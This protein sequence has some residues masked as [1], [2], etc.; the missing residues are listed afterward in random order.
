MSVD[1][2]HE[3][4]WNPEVTHIYASMM[5][6]AAWT[7][8]LILMRVFIVFSEPWLSLICSL[9]VFWIIGL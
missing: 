1:I 8:Q 7:M 4:T 9:D 6:F 5:A 2:V 3:E